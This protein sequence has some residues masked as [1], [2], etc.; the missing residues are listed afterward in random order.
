V[1]DFKYIEAWIHSSEKDITTRKAAAW[2]AFGRL[3]QLWKA[4]LLSRKLKKR[5]FLATVESVLLYGCEAWTQPKDIASRTH[6]LDY[7]TQYQYPCTKAE[8]T[9]KKVIGGWHFFRKGGSQIYYRRVITFWI[10]K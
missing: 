6:V 5:L 1:E 2:R 8:L 7:P 9:T 10:E 3:S 4:N